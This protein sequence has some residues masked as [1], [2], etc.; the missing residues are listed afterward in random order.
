M[1][2]KE[3]FQLIVK[4]LSAK[5][6]LDAL[7]EKVEALDVGAIDQ[8][9]KKKLPRGRTGRKLT[10]SKARIIKTTIL[11]AKNYAA[12]REALARRFNISKQ[13]I[14]MVHNGQTWSHVTPINQ[15]GGNV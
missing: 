14:D 10:A 11:S 8:V 12:A 7:G 9:P 5:D 2:A 4:D 13:S 1:D 6:L 3:L 15:E